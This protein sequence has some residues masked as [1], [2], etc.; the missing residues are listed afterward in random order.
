MRPRGESTELK[1]T[2]VLRRSPAQHGAPFGSSMAR[3]R[4]RVAGAA[5]PGPWHSKPA[6]LPDDVVSSPVDFTSTEKAFEGTREMAC[7]PNMKATCNDTQC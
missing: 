4:G 3:T 1:G 6:C 5:S 7:V 2:H